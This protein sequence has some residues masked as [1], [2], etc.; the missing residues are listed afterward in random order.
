M[1]EGDPNSEENLRAV[2]DGESLRTLANGLA[3]VRRM[4]HEPVDMTGLSR[5]EIVDRSSKRS[6][7]KFSSDWNLARY[8]EWIETQ[9]EE[10]EWTAES[11]PVTATVVFEEIVGISGGKNVRTIRLRS[12][13]RYVHAYPEE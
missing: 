1:A 6:G 9:I 11:G 12:D 10:L 3:I 7:S 8:M 13:G 4:K 2:P 5:Q